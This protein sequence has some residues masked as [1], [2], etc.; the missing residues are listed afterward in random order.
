VWCCYLSSGSRSSGLLIYLEAGTL[1]G[2]PSLAV[3]E[4]FAPGP[5][6]QVS[7]AFT[8]YFWATDKDFLVREYVEN[9]KSISQIAREIG[10]ARS[11]VGAALNSFGIRRL[12]RSPHNQGGQI[13]YGKRFAKG[14]VVR[15]RKEEAVIRDIQSMRANGFSYEK[16]AE[17]LNRTNIPTKSRS[18]HWSRSTIYKI[19]QSQK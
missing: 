2:S 5:E 8:S 13:A 4:H 17:R 19:V 12:A 18:C 16:I 6:I 9:S 15:H 10:C 3:S 7:T 11:T 14:Y 1:N